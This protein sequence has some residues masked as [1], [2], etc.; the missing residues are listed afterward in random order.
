MVLV[1]ARQE[2]DSCERRPNSRAILSHVKAKG[3]SRRS[4]ENLENNYRQLVGLTE[5]GRVTA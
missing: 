1:K 3:N 2:A 4:N 5:I